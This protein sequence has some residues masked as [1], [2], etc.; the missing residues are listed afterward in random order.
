MTSNQLIVGITPPR[1]SADAIKVDSLGLITK[2]EISYR[3]S[4]IDSADT[5]IS[6]NGVEFQGTVTS[7]LDYSPSYNS[8]VRLK[9]AERKKVKE[10][11]EFERQNA[12]EL[13][14]YRRLEKKFGGK[15]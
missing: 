6:L 14:E 5:W 13:A 12:N 7:L 11:I 10:W 2:M 1:P 3:Q 4:G 8:L 9:D 15:A